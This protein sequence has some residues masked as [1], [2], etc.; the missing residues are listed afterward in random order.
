MKRR[1]IPVEAVAMQWMKDAEFRRA[2]TALEEESA[3]ASAVIK[4]CDGANMTQGQLAD[5]TRATL[6]VAAHK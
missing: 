1:D 6:S 5:A 3:L 4:A 2:Y